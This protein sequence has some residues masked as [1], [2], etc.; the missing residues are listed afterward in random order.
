MKE[1][2]PNYKLAYKKR[3]IPGLFLSSH[4]KI[5]ATKRKNLYESIVNKLLIDGD[6]FSDEKKKKLILIA[7]LARKSYKK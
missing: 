5:E 3:G 7:N 2:K 1:K 6:D 4:E